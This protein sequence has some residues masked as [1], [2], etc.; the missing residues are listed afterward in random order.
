MLQRTIDQKQMNITIVLG[1]KIPSIKYG[2]TQ[3]VMWYLGKELDKRGHKVT[4]IA[5]KGSYCPF[6]K[7]IE[8]DPAGNL[9]AQIPADTDLVHFN[10]PVP[11]G[12]TKPH[13]LTIHGNGIPANAD[14]NIVFVSR[15]HAQRLGS[16]S[17]VYNGLDWDDYGP[18]NLTL[19][20]KN[21]HFLGKAAWKVKNMKGAIAVV[22]SIKNAQLDVLGG[23]RLN[24]KMGFRFTWNPRIHFHGMVDDSKKK[25]FIEQ[26]KGLIFP[27]TWHEPF[28][29]AITE[30]LNFGAPVF[31]T[32]YGAL[33]ELVPPEVGFL[34]THRQEMAEH[35]QSAQYSPKVC[36]EYARDLFNSS[37]MAEAYL[38]K[39][40]TVLNGEPL[41][42]EVPHVIDIARRLPWD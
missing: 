19:S 3:R 35:I 41:N 15:N 38:K 14:R 23:Y 30:S 32:P 29:L 17:F 2:G 24:L 12:I 34:T 6:A 39:Y 1:D 33:P 13:L 36:H 40:E 9:N 21:Y 22:E 27:V 26:S 31:G 5:G 37:V 8:L 16:E 10:I 28:G 11:D 4:F 18:A 7:V 20:R 25:G 42:K